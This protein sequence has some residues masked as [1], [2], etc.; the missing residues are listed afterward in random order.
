MYYP[1]VRVA[2]DFKYL[3]YIF[4][5]LEQNKKEK[6]EKISIPIIYLKFKCNELFI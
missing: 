6:R 5:G 1:Q 3:A 4:L 2:K